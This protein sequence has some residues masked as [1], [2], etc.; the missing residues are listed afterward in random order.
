MLLILNNPNKKICL[1]DLNSADVGAGFSIELID[2]NL[3]PFFNCLIMNTDLY[4]ILYF[5][6]FFFVNNFFF[7]KKKKNYKQTKPP[8][9]GVYFS[10]LE[11]I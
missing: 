4:Q 11:S 2:I 5:L 1:F 7:K 6:F 10:I 8:N 3:L 9:G